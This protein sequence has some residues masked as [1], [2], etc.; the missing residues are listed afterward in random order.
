MGA[1]TAAPAAAPTCP[2]SGWRSLV[3]GV[4]EVV[5]D[6]P[7]GGDDILLRFDLSLI[8]SAHAQS[9]DPVLRENRKNGSK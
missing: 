6:Q 1:G 4:R 2:R 7:F 8:F 3:A 9:I 5:D